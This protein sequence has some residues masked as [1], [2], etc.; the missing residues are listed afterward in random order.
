MQNSDDDVDS[1]R[2]LQ[3]KIPGFMKEVFGLD[4]TDFKII[5]WVPVLYQAWELDDL[6]VLIQ[7]SDQRK[8]LLHTD[9]GSLV[10]VENPKEFLSERIDFYKSTIEKSQEALNW[11][12]L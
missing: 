8:I 11:V 1:I 7:T 4:T 10:N 2:V 5:A 12:K 9:H 6:A 3:K